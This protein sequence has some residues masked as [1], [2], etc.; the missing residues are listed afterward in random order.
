MATDPRPRLWAE[1]EVRMAETPNPYDTGYD[2]AVRW[3]ELNSLDRKSREQRKE[4]IKR[5]EQGARDAFDALIQD[6]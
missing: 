5:F 6:S 3:W 2:A 1:S 4:A